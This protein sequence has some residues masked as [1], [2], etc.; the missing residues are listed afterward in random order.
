MSYHAHKLRYIFTV[1]IK[2]PCCKILITLLVE[3]LTLIGKKTVYVNFV[4]AT[5]IVQPRWW[6]WKPLYLQPLVCLPLEFLPPGRKAPR[7]RPAA[8]QRRSTASWLHRVGSASEKWRLWKLV[9]LLYSSMRTVLHFIFT[10]PILITI[11]SILADDAN[12][13][14]CREFILVCFSL[15]SF[16][17]FYFLEY[18]LSLIWR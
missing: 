10:A 11:C 1:T 8:R 4:P 6:E 3:L 5:A 18:W 16:I 14:L 15:S 9:L 7:M 12:T 13:L 17:L 2:G